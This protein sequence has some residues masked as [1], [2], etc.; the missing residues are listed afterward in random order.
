[1]ANV[2]GDR[3]VLSIHEVAENIDFSRR[4]LLRW[5]RRGRDPEPDA[6]GVAGACF[7]RRK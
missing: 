5:M 6:T 7:R 3:C 4:T 1:M 2:L